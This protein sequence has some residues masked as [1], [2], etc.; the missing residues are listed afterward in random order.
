MDC[1]EIEKNRTLSRIFNSLPYNQ[2]IDVY[3]DGILIF[4]DLKY[5]EFSPYVYVLGGLHKIDVY[6]AGKKENPIIR[7]SINLP[8]E[9]IFT[10]AVVGNKDQESLLVIDEDITQRPS[11]DSAVA[12]SVNLSP[13][14]PAVDVFVDGKP[15]V[16]NI[17]FRDQTPYVYIP[18]GKYEIEV[19]SSESNSQIAKETFEFKANR[20]YTIYITGNPPNVVL[21]NSV[22]GNTYA[23]SR[24]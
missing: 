18:L 8:L 12:R 21:I 6:E 16:S 23:C 17:T 19:K 24:V 13:D 7:T 15:S 5:T 1:F 11:M 3:G 9:Q 22:D 10:I 4:S 2:P 14:I 20:I